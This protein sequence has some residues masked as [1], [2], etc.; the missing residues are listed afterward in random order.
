MRV[1]RHP[2]SLIH[3]FYL[4]INCKSGYALTIKATIDKLHWIEIRQ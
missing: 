3:A 2:G 4:L 1:E